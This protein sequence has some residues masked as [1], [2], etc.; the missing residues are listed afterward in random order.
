MIDRF[1]RSIMSRVMSN[2]ED[3]AKRSY[4]FIRIWAGVSR[5]GRNASVACNTL[6]DS[7]DNI[8]MNFLL[9]IE[10]I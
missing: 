3:N 4:H 8:P 5:I 10:T 6:S 9:A 7:H 2:K 1:M